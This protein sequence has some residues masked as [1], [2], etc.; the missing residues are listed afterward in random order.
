MSQLKQWMESGSMEM[1]ILAG[2]GGA[3]SIQKQSV[4]MRWS[5]LFQVQICQFALFLNNKD[6]DH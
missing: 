3:N 4:G 2:K 5:F 6:Y 1:Q